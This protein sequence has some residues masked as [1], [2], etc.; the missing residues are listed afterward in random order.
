MN[1]YSHSGRKAVVAGLVAAILGLSA[2]CGGPRAVD[3]DIKPNRASA[4]PVEP[5]PSLS[6]EDQQSV[7]AAWANFLKL[8]GIYIK[9]A[10]TGKYDWAPDITARPMYAY[11]GGR[12][13]S[14]LERDLDVLAEQ[15]YVR[16]GQPSVALRRVVSVSETSIVVEA[17]VDD[18]GTDTVDK[19]T[20]KS[21]A[22]PKQNQRYPVTMRAGLYPDG[23]WRWVE[24]QADRGASC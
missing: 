6:P 8:N 17:C 23:A 11:S 18:A 16:T 22:A 20:G 4:K 5:G 12:Y 19:K 9:A 13:M 1:P 7:D 21:V 24:S 2:G 10:Q 3:P 15:G 14:A